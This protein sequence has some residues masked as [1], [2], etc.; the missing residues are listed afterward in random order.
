M[1]KSSKRTKRKKSVDEE[2]NDWNCAAQHKND[3]SNYSDP[4]QFLKNG[5]VNHCR[6][7]GIPKAVFITFDKLINPDWK[8]AEKKHSQKSEV[9]GPKPVIPFLWL[10]NIR[11]QKMSA[12]IARLP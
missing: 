1:V 10:D 6:A 12:A 11:A 9:N 3:I 7:S 8:D 2:I 4:R 5:R